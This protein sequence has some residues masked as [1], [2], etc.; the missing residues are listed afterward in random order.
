PGGPTRLTR[1]DQRPTVDGMGLYFLLLDGRLFREAIRPAL[2]AA[3]RQRSFE[4]CRSLAAQLEPAVRAFTTRYHLGTD[5]PLLAQVPRGL[6]FDRHFWTLLAGEVLLYAAAEA[7][8]IQ[9]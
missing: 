1:A 3:W 4:P 9:T 8:D 6:P 5:E 7:P 2:A